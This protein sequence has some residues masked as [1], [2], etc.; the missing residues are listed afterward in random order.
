MKQTKNN[1]RRKFLQ[2]TTLASLAFLASSQTNCDAKA[3]NILFDNNT[4]PNIPKDLKIL[5]Q[6]DSITDGGRNRGNYYANNS[7]GMGSGYVYQIVSQ[8]LGEHPDKQF[9]CYNRGISGHKVFQLDNRWEDDC[10]NLKPDVLSILIGVNDFWHSL[11]DHYNGTAKT[12]ETDLRKLLART[13]KALPNVKLILAEPFAV[14]GGTAVSDPKWKTEF[15]AY[16]VA[17]KKLADEFDANFL[18]FQSL[19]DNALTKA[20]VAYWCPDGVHPSMAG[21]HL[22]AKAWLEV[23]YQL[24]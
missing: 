4:I 7:H 16:R 5:L 21:S 20:P 6:G 19:F 10:L 13:K 3:N 8:L 14:D 12:Y 22:M 24:F 18:P 2:N 23:F 9:K 15:P 1:Q 17:S 11:G